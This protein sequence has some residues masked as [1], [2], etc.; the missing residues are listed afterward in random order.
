MQK[1][2]YILLFVIL[3]FLVI[4][5]VNNSKGNEIVLKEGDKAPDFTALNDEG[6]KVSLSDF[7]GKIVV[8]Y[9]YPKDNTPGCTNEAC[10]F[11]DSYEKIKSLGVVVLGISLDNEESHKKFKEKYNLPFT[12]L[13]DKDGEISKE[14]GTYT[15][16]LRTIKFAKRMT[17]IIDGNG[18]IKKIYK[19]VDVSRHS[20]EVYNDIKSIFDFEK[21]DSE[22]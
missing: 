14:Y 18:I 4:F 3:F 22:L 21:K 15:Q 19:K 5:I 16:Y 17:F 1:N 8:L 20:E 2:Y 6:K 12:L 7:K 9:F 11:R 13:S 10:S